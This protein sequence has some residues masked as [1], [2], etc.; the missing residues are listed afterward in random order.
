[1]GEGKEEGGRR[2]ERRGRGWESRGRKEGSTT[3]YRGSLLLLIVSRLLRPLY[4]LQR[5][6]V[7]YSFGRFS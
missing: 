3:V 7:M 1:M 5:F 6:G 4:Y 2:E